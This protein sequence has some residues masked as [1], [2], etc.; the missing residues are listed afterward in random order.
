MTFTAVLYAIGYTVA[1]LFGCFLMYKL[2]VRHW[3]SE[4]DTLETYELP[5][6]ALSISRKKSCC[7][8]DEFQ[9]IVREKINNDEIVKSVSPL[10]NS[11]FIIEINIR[12]FN[13]FETEYGSVVNIIRH[14]INLRIPNPPLPK[15]HTAKLQ[16][17]K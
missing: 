7:T 12:D 9:R 2:I 17:T 11:M 16:Q 1:V 6:I 5:C 15:S 3:R 8:P 10:G 4:G 13:S 14:F